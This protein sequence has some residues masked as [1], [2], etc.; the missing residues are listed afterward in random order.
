MES[1]ISS[2][3]KKLANINEE[4]AKDYGPQHEWLTLKDVCVEKNEGE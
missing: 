4:L 3:E 2:I 1:E